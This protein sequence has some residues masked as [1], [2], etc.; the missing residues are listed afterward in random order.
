VATDELVASAARTGK[1]LIVA[2][3]TYGDA[4]R[5]GAATADLG[6]PVVLSGW[7]YNNSVDTLAAARRGPHLHVETSG[8]AHMG[9]IEIAVGAIGHERVLYGSG[10][11][12]RA[13]Q[14]SI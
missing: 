12:F 4:S 9:A 13:M 1:P 14:S 2:I 6:V 10:A 7:H 5:V 11:P 3:A 8:A